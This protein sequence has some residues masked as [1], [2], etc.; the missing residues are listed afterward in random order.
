MGEMITSCYGCGQQLGGTT[1]ALAPMGRLPEK[2]D[3]FES[4]LFQ[5]RGGMLVFCN[6]TCIAVLK[7]ALTELVKKIK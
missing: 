7:I 3:H 1:L 5:S 4:I 2:V 6:D